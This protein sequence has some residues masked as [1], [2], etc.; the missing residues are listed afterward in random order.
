[1]PTTRTRLDAASAP[2]LGY[3]DDFIKNIDG[4]W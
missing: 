4:S 2:E 1:V 3:P